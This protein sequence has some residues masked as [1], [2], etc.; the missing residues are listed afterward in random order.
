MRYEHATVPDSNAA[1]PTSGAGEPYGAD[2][3]EQYA[4]TTAGA[5]PPSDSKWRWRKRWKSAGSTAAGSSHD[6]SDAAT[7]ADEP[8]PSTSDDVAAST[9]AAVKTGTRAKNFDAD[10][11]EPAS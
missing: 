9:A 1:I 11:A 4:T 10:G 7:A 3:S 5:K 6:E 2:Q 8:I